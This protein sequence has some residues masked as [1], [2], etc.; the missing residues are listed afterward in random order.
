MTGNTPEQ[1]YQQLFDAA[2][3]P[4][5][6]SCCSSKDTVVISEAVGDDAAQWC[7]ARTALQGLQLALQRHTARNAAGSS[8]SSSMQLPGI[9]QQ[10]LGLL[11]GL[12]AVFLLLRLTAAGHSTASTATLC[13]QVMLQLFDLYSSHAAKAPA[14]A[15]AEAKPYS[16]SSSSSG[17][18]LSWAEAQKLLNP[19]AEL[20]DVLRFGGAAVAAAAQL[21]SLLLHAVVP[22]AAGIMQQGQAAEGW[23][24]ALPAGERQQQLAALR[25]SLGSLV[26][27]ATLAGAQAGS[28]WF[29]AVHLCQPLYFVLC[30]APPMCV[31]WWPLPNARQPCI[32]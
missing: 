8:S 10:S 17:D 12:A 18:V 6:G 13:L 27:L 14:E 21:L 15:S 5:L 23:A 4:G 29:V 31:C 16:S 20:P 1:L 11:Q 19:T 25:A 9:L 3:V 22:A 32:C 7:E 30:W 24:A 26:M 2:G 28:A